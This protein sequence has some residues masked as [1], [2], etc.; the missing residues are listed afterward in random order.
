MGILFRLK[1]GSEIFNISKDI[2]HRKTL[3]AEGLFDG[4]HGR[5]LEIFRPLIILTLKYMPEWKGQLERYIRKYIES[6]QNSEPTEAHL[7]LIA[8]KGIY[9][10]IVGTTW[11]SID[12]DEFGKVA[13][14]D[15]EIYGSIIN[16]P[17]KLISE[18]IKLI[19]SFSKMSV[20]SIGMKMDELGF[21]GVNVK[22]LR[23]VKISQLN[24]M[25]ERYLGKS[26]TNTFEASLSLAERLTLVRDILNGGDFSTDDIFDKADGKL[27]RKQVQSLIKYYRER[28]QV[29]KVG[30]KYQWIGD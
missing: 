16:F 12:T 5:T 29:I 20:K 6:R 26:L 7:L 15:D 24:D 14:R 1:C 30:E 22:G 23:T 3:D 19:T 10:E 13:I 2:N 25:S 9:E 28:G 8:M 17:I 27:Q 21:G 18:R 11:K 4:I